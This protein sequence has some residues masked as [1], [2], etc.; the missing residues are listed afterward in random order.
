MVK[1]GAVLRGKG[2]Q[3][4]LFPDRQGTTKS[5]RNMDDCV[6]KRVYGY[7]CAYLLLALAIFVTNHFAEMAVFLAC[8][9]G[10]V[11]A[12]CYATAFNVV[13]RRGARLL[14]LT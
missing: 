1:D 2:L 7:V 4:E 12:D 5:D 11:G 14:F 8:L 6:T 3:K 10:Y 9:G 13:E